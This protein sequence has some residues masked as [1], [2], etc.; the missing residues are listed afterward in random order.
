MFIISPVA[1]R[2]TKKSTPAA[3]TVV[4][5]Q[6]PGAVPVG[7]VS[8]QPIPAGAGL[9]KL[10]ALWNYI[11][12]YH[13]IVVVLEMDIVFSVGAQCGRL[14]LKNFLT[15]HSCTY[16]SFMWVL[17]ILSPMHKAG[18]SYFFFYS[19]LQIL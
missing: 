19:V 5:Q 9:L 16:I 6:A 7:A 15:P 11:G 13:E 10:L 12:L 18:T 17:F 4:S 2:P 8:G 14:W 1:S 3:Q